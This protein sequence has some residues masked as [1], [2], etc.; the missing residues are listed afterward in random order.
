[1]KQFV[2]AEGHG[3]IPENYPA[4]EALGRWAIQKRKQKRKL[5][6]GKPTRL[7]PERVQ[8]L[9]EA[10]FAWKIWGNRS[11]KWDEMYQKLVQ[12]KA[13]HG[14][15]HIVN[16]AR[17]ADPDHRKLG[18]WCDRQKATYKLRQQGKNSPMTEER[19]KRLED[20]G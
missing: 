5:D 9:E 1:M 18:M 8:Q 17:M 13:E 11:E 6:A 12:Y 10:G 16:S 19:I 4:N 7:T 3:A 2:A 20:I 14:T 15:V